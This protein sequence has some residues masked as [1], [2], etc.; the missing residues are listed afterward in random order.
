MD[1]SRYI[2]STQGILTEVS[3]AAKETTKVTCKI[4]V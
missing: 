2:D 3:K 1:L 4:Y